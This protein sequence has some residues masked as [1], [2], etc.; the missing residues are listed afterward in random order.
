MQPYWI[1]KEHWQICLSI[2]D[3]YLKGQNRHSKAKCHKVTWFFLW[4]STNACYEIQVFHKGSIFLL[5]MAPNMLKWKSEKWY[6][7]L[8]KITPAKVGEDY[9]HTFLSENCQKLCFAWE[10]GCSSIPLPSAKPCRMFLMNWWEIE[11]GIF[12][13]RMI[14]IKV[15]RKFFGLRSFASLRKKGEGVNAWRRCH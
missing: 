14:L 1:I 7:T 9:K 11:R 12:Y 10:V 8:P 3:H 4:K 6:C 5:N 2:I 13:Q 15:Q